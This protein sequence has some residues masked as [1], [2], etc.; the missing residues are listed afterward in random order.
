LKKNPNPEKKVNKI[1][2]LIDDPLFAL[3]FIAYCRSQ[4]PP[5]DHGRDDTDIINYAKWYVCRTRNVLFLDPIW[6]KYTNE[7]ILIEFLA[8]RFDEDKV[9]KESFEAQMNGVSEDEQAWFERMERK[10][11]EEQDKKS[12]EL[13]GDKEEIEDKFI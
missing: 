13:M 12:K 9:V 8:I 4:L 6:D 1:N 11:L 7:D 3:K 10:F 2:P 5:E